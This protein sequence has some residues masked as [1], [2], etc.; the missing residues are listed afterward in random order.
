MIVAELIWRL[1]EL[2]PEMP[3]VVSSLDG[4]G[5][6]TLSTLH[7]L[8]LAPLGSREFTSAEFA[9]VDDRFR[10]GE[11]HFPARADIPKVFKALSLT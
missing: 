4:K 8:E 9:E 2:P 5:F 3:V 6:D 10:G 1:K 7:E 11:T